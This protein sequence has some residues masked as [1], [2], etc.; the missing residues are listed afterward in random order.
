MTDRI[1]EELMRSPLDP[2]PGDEVPFSAQLALVALLVVSGFVVGRVIFARSDDVRPADRPVATATTT[3]D[4]TP[5]A[6]PDPIFPDGYVDVD[7]IGIVPIAVFSRDGN[8]YVVVNEATRSDQEPADTDG[9]HDGD[10]VLAGDERTVTATRAIRSPLAPGVMTIEFTGISELPSVG[11][12]LIVRR[13]TEM[14]VR[15]GC[16]GCAAVSTHEASGDITLDGL[17]IPYELDSPMLIDAGSGIVF[18]VDQLEFTDEWGY[19][20]WHIVGDN[21]Q[22]LR[23]QLRVVFEG[24]DD[25]DVAGTQTTQLV[26]V[27]LITTYQQNP[28]TANTEPFTRSGFSLLD[29]AGNLLN[30]DNK[31][32]SLAL[33]WSIEWL[34]PVGAPVALPLSAVVNLGAVG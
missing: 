18:S 15:A 28:T 4:T 32:T 24:T 25:P 17:E 3:A 33:S 26:P 23:T 6:E 22:R 13:G 20:E 1:W 14:A 9:F 34:A 2:D 10:W 5:A 29:R 8:L 27:N 12:S 31:P 30:G 19:A 16:Q 7:G 11:A 21:E